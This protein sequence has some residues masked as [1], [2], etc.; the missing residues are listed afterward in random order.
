MTPDENGDGR[1]LKDFNIE[2]RGFKPSDDNEWLIALKTQLLG[3]I[4]EMR[5]NGKEFFERS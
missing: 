1:K 4:E 2:V 5:D 3:I